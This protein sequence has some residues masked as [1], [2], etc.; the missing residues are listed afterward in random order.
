MKKN[1]YIRI[2][3]GL[4]VALSS[5]VLFSCNNDDFFILPDRGGM[6]SEL[7][8]NSEGAMNM[9]LN[10][11]YELIIPR[12]PWQTVPSRFD[13]HLVSDEH[14]FASNGSYGAQAMGIAGN[15]LINHDVR[16]VGNSYNQNYLDNR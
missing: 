15:A 5:A 7:L 2:R 9:H 12:F 1:I 14:F 3:K 13:I 8:W 11:A 4:L 16:Y 10:K 6:S